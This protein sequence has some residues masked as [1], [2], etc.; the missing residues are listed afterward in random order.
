MTKPLP[1]RAKNSFGVRVVE[2]IKAALGYTPSRAFKVSSGSV[3][4]FL[5]KQQKE[6]GI[7]LSG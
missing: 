1:I 4:T 6:L 3:R 7:L 5:K 2:K